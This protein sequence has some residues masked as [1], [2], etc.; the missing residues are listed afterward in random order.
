MKK[1][2]PRWEAMWER[3]EARGWEGDY[4]IGRGGGWEERRKEKW[5]IGW[6]MT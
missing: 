6:E 4:D 2:Q 1:G 5:M 3:R